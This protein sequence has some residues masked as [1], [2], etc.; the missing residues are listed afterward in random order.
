M[1][2]MGLAWVRVPGNH[3]A[4]GRGARWRMAS[5]R[6]PPFISTVRQ[7]PPA[8]RNDAAAAAAF[9][10]ERIARLLRLAGRGVEGPVEPR[11]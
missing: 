3:P 7:L 6:F 10:G 9:V 4:K 11:R 2:N 1:R 5:S 8:V